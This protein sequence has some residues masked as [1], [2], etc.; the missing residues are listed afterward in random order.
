MQTQVL[1]ADDAMFMRKVI[2]KHLAECVD[3]RYRRGG[4]WRRGGRVIYQKSPGAGTYGYHDA[5]NDG[6]GGFGGDT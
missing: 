2:R 1:I 3:D 4:K 5:G 6:A